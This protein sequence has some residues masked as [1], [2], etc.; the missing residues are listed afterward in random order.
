MTAGDRQS[1]HGFV[2]SPDFRWVKWQNHEFEFST[3]QAACIEYLWKLRLQ[4]IKGAS[5]H[6]ILVKIESNAFRLH[7]IFRNHPA[8]GKLLR[9][10][11]RGLY[12][13]DLTI[14]V[15]DNRIVKAD[16]DQHQISVF[17]ST[18]SGTQN[19]M[20]NPKDCLWYV[21]IPPGEFEM[22][23]TNPPPHESNESPL[24]HIVISKGFWLC[25]TPVTG[26]AF[27]TFAKETGRRHMSASGENYPIVGISW[28]DAADYCAW[29][30]GRLPTE[31]EWEYAARAGCSEDFYGPLDE[32]AWYE[33]NSGHL[34]QPVG[35]KK[36][37]AFGLYDILGNVWEW[38]SDWYDEDYYRISALSDPQGP[39]SGLERIIRG[40]ASGN[41]A[42]QLRLSE[43]GHLPPTHRVS[44]V[45]IRCLIFET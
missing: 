5:Q 7:D 43:R 16:L 32:I 26:K 4:G 39:K 35:E 12:W 9:G 31:A 45:G 21:Y 8:W 24:H 44:N 22:G 34:V 19:R 18:T 42:V 27:N 33:G 37:N 28:S 20:M 25:E 11:K 15:K 36:P 2:A 23:C 38:C 3:L 30:G 13:L 10:N 17:P 1:T 41:D 40:G 29:A 6:T 14:D